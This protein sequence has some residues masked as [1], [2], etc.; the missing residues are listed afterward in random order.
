MASKSCTNSTGQMEGARVDHAATGARYTWKI[1]TG[2]R[3]GKLS[4]AKKIQL[5]QAPVASWVCEHSF[6]VFRHL[7]SEFCHPW[8]E[9]LV[10]FC[11]CSNWVKFTDCGN[12]IQYV[13]CIHPSYNIPCFNSPIHTLHNSFPWFHILYRPTLMRKSKVIGVLSRVTISKPGN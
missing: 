3:G 10:F 2:I 1:V 11:L 5:L 9:L 4:T 12:C 7:R 8:T 6:S 13:T